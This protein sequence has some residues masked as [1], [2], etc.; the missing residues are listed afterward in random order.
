VAS[1][2][3]LW[4]FVIGFMICVAFV[5]RCTAQECA[6]E[7]KDEKKAECANNAKGPTVDLRSNGEYHENPVDEFMYFVPLISPVDVTIEISANN[8]QVGNLVSYE[9][10]KTDKNFYA[11]CEFRMKGDG[12]YTNYF[13]PNGMLEWN[14]EETKRGKT[15]K[16]ILDYIKFEGEGYGRV[17]VK[18][19]FTDSGKV[20][21]NVDVHFDA[22]SEKSPVTVGLYTLKPV[23]GEYDYK[24][25]YNMMVARVRTLSF[26][27]SDAVPE[28]AIKVGAVGSDEDSLGGWEQF[29]G[30]LANFLIK[31]I[32][33]DKDGN[34]A[35]LDF[36]LALYEEYEEFTFPKATKLKAKIIK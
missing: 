12:Y 29:K 8:K 6:S 3:L 7:A 36:G 23:D 27:K 30:F 33:V 34:Q 25:R 19:K 11:S 20:V 16:N 28:M 15:L 17:D 1:K 10:R 35:M 21:T 4:L 5:F 14:M 32:K 2:K 18:G 13:D 31:P 24:D 26:E 22:R 9:G